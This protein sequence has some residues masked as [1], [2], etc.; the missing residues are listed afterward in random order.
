MHNELDSLDSIIFNEEITTIMSHIY[1][2]V[3]VQKD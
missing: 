3:L 2:T 1:N